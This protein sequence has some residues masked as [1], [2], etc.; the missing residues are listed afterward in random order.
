M[1]FIKAV[2]NWCATVGISAVRNLLKN[3]SRGREL[4]S[5]PAD[6]ESAALPLSY[7]GACNDNNIR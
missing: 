1:S 5:R 6:Y 3:W 7:L 2:C 4:N